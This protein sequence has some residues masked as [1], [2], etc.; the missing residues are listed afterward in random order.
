[1]DFVMWEV[2]FFTLPSGR[3]Q[4]D[5][6]ISTLNVKIDKPYIEKAFSRLEEYGNELVMPHAKPLRDKIY[7]LR[8]KTRNGQFRFLYFFDNKKII[9]THGFKKKTSSVPNNQINLA[10]NYRNMHF[11]SD[12]T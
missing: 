7:E 10:I 3:C 5:E 12:K 8:V 11:E 1:M 6:Y 9:V 4:V 2:E